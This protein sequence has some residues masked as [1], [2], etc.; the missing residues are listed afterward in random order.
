M[1][2]YGCGGGV[3]EQQILKLKYDDKYYNGTYIT[4]IEENE[5]ENIKYKIKQIMPPASG[6]FL[7]ERT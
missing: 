2:K 3:M 4:I 7:I 6:K 1:A 5:I